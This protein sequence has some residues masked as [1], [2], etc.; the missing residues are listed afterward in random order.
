MDICKYNTLSLDSMGSDCF[1]EAISC[2]MDYYGLIYNALHYNFHL[3][4]YNFNSLLE[5]DFRNPPVDYLYDKN[6]LLFKNIAYPSIKY[7]TDFNTYLSTLTRK[8]NNEILQNVNIYDTQKVENIFNHNECICVLVDPFHLKDIY[9]KFNPDLVKRLR[10]IPHYINIFDYN[11]KKQSYSILD[12]NYSL[13]ITISKSS[14]EKSFLKN[15]FESYHIKK[16]FLTSN[17]IKEKIHS[18]LLQSLHKSIY[19]NGTNYLVNSNGWK[20]LKEDHLLLL[21]ELEPI[22]KT[23]TPQ[24]LSF[25]MI[26]FRH[27][28]K[29]NFRLFNHLSLSYKNLTNLAKLYEDYSSLISIYDNKLDLIYLRGDYI[30]DYSND[31]L[32][33]ISN[34]YEI[35]KRIDEETYNILCHWK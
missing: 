22:T 8:F 5:Y 35:S 34:I 20:Q 3:F 18:N 30:G 26:R 25:P 4:L 33:N 15:G 29:A 23:Y 14:L 24:Y 19:I 9:T 31:L 6:P 2:A 12:I 32:K 13:K 21:T 10:H 11:R 28:E 16:K 1:D 17:Q 7:K 27:M